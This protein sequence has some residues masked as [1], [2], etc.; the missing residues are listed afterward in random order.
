MKC[1]IYENSDNESTEMYNTTII[2]NMRKYV[3]WNYRKRENINMLDL[4]SMNM[5]N[6]E[7]L[8][9]GMGN[10]EIYKYENA[11]ICNMEMRKCGIIGNREIC[12]CRN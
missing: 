2:C 10:L 8:N 7:H 1:K 12:I 5:R 6:S 4:R 9:S 11:K 3:I